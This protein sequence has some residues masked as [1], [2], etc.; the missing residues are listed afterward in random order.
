MEKSISG[1][2]KMELIMV[3]ELTYTL[4]EENIKVNSVKG[5]LMELGYSYIQTAQNI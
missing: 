4:T 3:R 2:G 5:F 1:N